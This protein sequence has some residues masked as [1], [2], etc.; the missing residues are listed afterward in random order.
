LAVL[1]GVVIAA[2]VVAWMIYPPALGP[3]SGQD[4]MVFHAVANAWLHGDSTLAFHGNRLTA[5]INIRHAAWLTRPIGLHP[6][7]YPPS[8]L[9]LLLP[10]GALP[11]LLSWGLFQALTASLLALALWHS[12]PRGGARVMLVL[13][14][15]LCPAVPFNLVLGQNA[16]LTAALLVG[17]FALLPSAPLLGGVLFGVLTFKPQ[18]AL[19][20]PVALLAAGNRRALAGMALGAAAL[21]LA[22]LAV[23]GW[24]FWA[25]WIGLMLLPNPHLHA[26]LAAGRDHGVSLYACAAVLGAGPRLANLIQWAGTAAAAAA[27]FLLMRGKPPATLGLAGLLIATILAAPH[28]ENYDMVML[29]VAAGLIFCHGLVHDLRRG[30]IV[31]ALLLWVCPLVNPPAMFVIGTLTPVLLASALVWL[32]LRAPARDRL[33]ASP[34]PGIAPISA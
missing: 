3:E 32:L 2:G 18:L 11:F 17:G 5:L 27:V 33:A 25:R 28:A 20:V 8:F 30:H 21:G 15:A 19:L 14:A 10:F 9:L 34:S 31:F 13:V 23:F 22:S 1:A 16:F 29:G 6:W 24:T 26:W 7:L 12:G 4:W